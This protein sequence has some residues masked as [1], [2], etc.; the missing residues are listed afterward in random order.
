MIESLLPYLSVRRMCMDTY[1]A[2]G[3]HSCVWPG[4]QLRVYD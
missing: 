1:E 3:Q 4:K 2:K